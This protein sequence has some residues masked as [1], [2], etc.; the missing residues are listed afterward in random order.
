[1]K[2]I[3]QLATEVGAA[4]E[5]RPQQ[6]PLWP[7]TERVMPVEFIAASVFT[8]MQGQRTP[9][10]KKM[11]VIG[12][13]NGYQLR[14]KGRRLTQVHAD[15]WQGIL[16]IAQWYGPQFER[17]I[18]FGAR[19]LLRVIGRGTSKAARGQLHEWLTDMQACALEIIMPGGRAG[20]SAPIFLECSWIRHPKTAELIYQLKPNPKLCNAFERGF[21]T[22]DWDRRARLRRNELACWL[23]QYLG[24]F[25]M[26]VPVEALHA[27]SARASTLKEFRRKLR[28]AMA[29]ICREKLVRDW[30]IDELDQLVIE[31][32]NRLRS[33]GGSGATRAPSR[34]ERSRLFQNISRPAKRR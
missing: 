13:W 31:L 9:H 17:T 32:P 33:E 3:D 26:P 11:T 14:Y 28:D 16:E 18:E 27:L 21:S 6:L 4:I 25:P 8:A 1:M 30:R 20:F 24:A 22:I 5:A 12:E 19:Q 10:F 34:G 7:P 23:Q 29:L 15:V 2:S